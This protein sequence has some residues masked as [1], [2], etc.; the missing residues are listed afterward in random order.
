MIKE[1]IATALF[2]SAIGT[3]IL[4]KKL[5]NTN[6]LEGAYCLRNNIDDNSFDYDDTTYDFYIDQTQNIYIYFYIDN[7]NY[8]TYRISEIMQFK[9]VDS[10]PSY[11]EFSFSQSDI[12]RQYW[13]RY[14]FGGGNNEGT[15]SGNI[16][17]YRTI[18]YF[19]RP[20]YLDRD[21]K[22]RWDMYFTHEGNSY[23]SVYTG[24][25][26]MNNNYIAPIRNYQIFGNFIV[27]NNLYTSLQYTSDRG[28][29]FEA[30]LDDFNNDFYSSIY[31]WRDNQYQ[32]NDKLIYFTDVMIPQTTMINLRANGV[33]AYAY[34]PVNYT[35]GEMIFNII[36]A[37]I[38]MLSQLFSFTLFGI[39][40]YIAFIGIVTII[41]ICFIVRK[42][43]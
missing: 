38:Y 26:T 3:N 33:F 42:I 2:S 13:F 23:C 22:H 15:T 21:T 25:Y 1:I 9:M 12:T 34:E 19:N 31:I 17:P 11:F 43:V 16:E 20:Y 41:L 18:V 6:V 29:A 8:Y 32:I 24:W 39:E 36:D 27:N 40:F 10:D 35:F 5:A 4:P 30:L 37:P 14:Y 7:S 28:G